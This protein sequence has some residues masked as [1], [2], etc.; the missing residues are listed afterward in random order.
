MYQTLEIYHDNDKKNDEEHS[1]PHEV[2][3]RNV[4]DKHIISYILTTDQ[5]D[6]IISSSVYFSITIA[7]HHSFKNQ[8]I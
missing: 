6:H 4:K 3:D 2:R 1:I 7:C 8:Y 5:K